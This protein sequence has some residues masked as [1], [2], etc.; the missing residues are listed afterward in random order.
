VAGV[1]RL[2][3]ACPRRLN[4]A[5]QARR[6]H[7]KQTAFEIAIPLRSNLSPP[8]LLPSSEPVTALRY[9]NRA[10]EHSHRLTRA[11][12]AGAA[13]RQLSSPPEK[14]ERVGREACGCAAQK[15]QQCVASF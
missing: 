8:L 3:K 11:A 1:V 12:L 9:S 6:P 4:F 2:I 5:C 14:R 13:V 15:A 10:F 7:H